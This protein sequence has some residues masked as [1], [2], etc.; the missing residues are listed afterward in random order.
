[1]HIALGIFR[2]FFLIRKFHSIVI[3]LALVGMLFRSVPTKLMSL[4][5]SP[6]SC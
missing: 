6:V 1:M 5:P 3:F 4:C 2:F